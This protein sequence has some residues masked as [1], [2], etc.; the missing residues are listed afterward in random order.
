MPVS[1]AGKEE[2]SSLSYIDMLSENLSKE[3]GSQ[4]NI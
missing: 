2:E 3:N 4:C 1:I